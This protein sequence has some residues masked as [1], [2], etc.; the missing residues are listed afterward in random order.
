MYGVTLQ[1]CS[2]VF[3]TVAKSVPDGAASTDDPVAFFPP[4]TVEA[5]LGFD[6]AG[7]GASALLEAGAGADCLDIA[8]IETERRSDAMLLQNF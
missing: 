1:I 7:A 2:Y 5:L 4:A 8:R 6:P 3:E